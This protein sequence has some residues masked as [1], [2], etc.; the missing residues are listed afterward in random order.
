MSMSLTVVSWPAYLSKHAALT[1]FTMQRCYLGY[2][3]CARID[4]TV[5]Y[6]SD[7]IELS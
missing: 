7:Y 1:V 4:F 6:R 2:L 3:L 5:A